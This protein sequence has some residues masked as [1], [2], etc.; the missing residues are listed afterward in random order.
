M[1]MK[2]PE[3]VNPWR[4][5][6]IGGCRELGLGLGTRKQGVAADWQ[7]VST[8]DDDDLLEL[9]VVTAARLCEHTKTH[10]PEDSSG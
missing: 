3:R 5:K 8:Q 10:R 2:C 9:K 6:R 7:E 4:R 1:Y